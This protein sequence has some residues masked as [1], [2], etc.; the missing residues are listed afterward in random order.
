VPATGESHSEGNG[1]PDRD[2]DDTYTEPEASMA[3]ALAGHALFLP[4][5]SHGTMRSFPPR[6]A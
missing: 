6:L 1:D 3:L 4:T 2:Q 5:S